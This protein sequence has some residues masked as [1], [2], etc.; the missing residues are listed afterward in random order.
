MTVD[1][2]LALG[3]GL[4]A[5]V[6]ALVHAALPGWPGVG[7]MLVGATVLLT[8]ALWSLRTQP[9]KPTPQ[10]R[11]VTRDPAVDAALTAMRNA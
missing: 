5:I 7:V 8:S 9:C 2:R 11:P 1:P 3:A 6:G 4:S 10:E